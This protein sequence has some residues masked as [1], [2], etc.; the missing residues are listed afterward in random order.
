MM[1]VRVRDG[2]RGA[3]TVRGEVAAC[4]EGVHGLLLKIL[5]N[6]LEVDPRGDA[7]G[8]ERGGITDA[9]ELQ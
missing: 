2:V 7:E 4:T 6:G 8:G 5:A 3:R 1:D 9:G